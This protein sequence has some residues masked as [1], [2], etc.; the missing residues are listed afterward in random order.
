M[1][2]KG[3][4]YSV[5]PLRAGAWRGERLG[6]AWVRSAKGR[7]RRRERIVVFFG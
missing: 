3:V 1:F 7:K 5:E 2:G 6:V 4:A